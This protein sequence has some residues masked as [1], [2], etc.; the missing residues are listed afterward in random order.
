MP[1]VEIGWK[2]WICKDAGHGTH[3]LREL[4][5]CLYLIMIICARIKSFCMLKRHQE[6][7]KCPALIALYDHPVPLYLP[8]IYHVSHINLP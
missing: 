4:T 3:H 7:N 2:V 5:L 6:A 1:S 8:P